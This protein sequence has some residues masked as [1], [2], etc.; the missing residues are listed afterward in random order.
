MVIRVNFLLP[1]RARFDVNYGAGC[2][3]LRGLLGLIH[4]R[5]FSNRADLLYVMAIAVEFKIVDTH[6]GKLFLHSLHANVSR[7]GLKRFIHWHL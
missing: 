2:C 4:G 6:A 5:V 3:N 1:L 7:L